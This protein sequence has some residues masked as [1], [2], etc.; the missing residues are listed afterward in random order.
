MKNYKTLEFFN[1]KNILFP[2]AQTIRGS[3]FLN[4]AINKTNNLEDPFKNL[5]VFKNSKILVCN[6][7]EKK[8]LE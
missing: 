2:H 1:E 6:D 8:I 3:Q 7:D 4:R 5:N